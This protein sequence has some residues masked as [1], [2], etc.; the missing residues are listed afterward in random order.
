M[1]TQFV[2]ER[3]EILSVL[4]HGGQGKVARALDHQHDRV[5]ALK[6]LEVGSEFE[7]RGLLREARMLLS[8]QPHPGLPIVREDFFDGDRYCIVMDWVEGV[9]LSRVLADRGAPGLPPPE[10]AEYLSQTAAALDHLHGHQPPV[11]H[12]DVKPGN[13][14][15]VPDGDVVLVDF[16]LSVPGGTDRPGRYGGTRGYAAPELAAGTATAAA[17]VYGLAATAF[18][19]LTGG[20]PR[21]DLPTWENIPRGTAG[22]I[23]P[24]IRQGLSIDPDRRQRSPGALAAAL[25]DAI[26]AAPA[27]RIA[28]ETQV[29]T[30]LIADVR[31]YTSFTRERGDEAAA[32]LA[33]AF[34]EVAREGVESRD[35]EVIELRGDEALA[36]FGSARQ[37]L[38]AAV[39]LQVV[40]Q[41]ESSLDPS[42]P[43]AVGIGLDAGEA[44]P[45]EGGFRGA[46]LN[47]AAR[48]CASA[49]P[50][51]VLVSQGVVHLASTVEGIRLEERVPL[52]LKGLDAPVP[53]WQASHDDA[54]SGPIGTSVEQ[55]H[56]RTEKPQV[57]LDV[58][59]ELDP[60]AR[61]VGRDRDARW[62]RWAWRQARRGPG[63]IVV[64]T[65]SEGAGKTLLAA[66]AAQLAAREGASVAYASSRRSSADVEMAIAAA[67]GSSGPTLLVLDDLEAAGDAE[68]AP[69]AELVDRLDERRLLVV[70]ILRDG[71]A[72]RTRAALE[73]LAGGGERIRGLGPFDRDGVRA[74][75]ALYVEE[76]SSEVPLD[77]ILQ[78]TGGAPPDVHRM[79][80]S[81]AEGEAAR[82]LGGAA[83]LA[84]RERAG[85]RT[86]EADVVSTVIDLQRV[87][88]RGEL[89]TGPEE[90]PVADEPP[91]KGLASFDVS[92]ARY[93]FGRERL[94]AE[95]VARLA[96]SSFLAVV[97]PSGSGKSSAV[98]AGLVPTLA[99]GALPGSE[100]WIRVMLRPG[101]HPERELDRVVFAALPERLRN[102]LGS[103]QTSLEAARSLVDE[104]DGH[105]LVVVDQ[106]EELFT[107]CQDDA[108]RERFLDSLTSAVRARGVTVL[109]AIRADFY[110]RCSAHPALAELVADNHVL[111]GPMTEE[112]YRRAIELP[113]RLAGLRIDRP[114]VDALVGEVVDEPGG[115]PLLST[116][117]LELWQR[118]HGRAL[119]LKSYSETGGVRG[120][121]ARLA[122]QAYA[123]LTVDQ[124]AVAKGVLLRLSTGEGEIVTRRRVPI[125]EFDPGTNADVGAV[126]D[127]LIEAR[128]LI[129]DDGSVEV[130]HEALLREWPRLEAWLDEDRAGRRLREHLTEQAKEWERSG[131]EAGDLYRGP[132]LA[133]AREWT[134]DHAKELNDLEREFLSESRVASERETER[135]RRTNRRLRG[136]LVG[137]AVFLVVA[138]LAGGLALVQQGRARDEADRAENHARIASGRELA[139][140]AVANLDVDPER[141]ILLALAAVDATWKADRTVQSAAEEALHRA[142]QESR[143][144]RTVPQGHA[145]AVNADGSRFATTGVDGTA[146]VWETATGKRL[147]TLRGHEGKVNGV[148]FSPDG[149]LL[150]TAGSDRTARLWDGASGRPVHVLRGH[151]DPVLGVAFGPDGSLLATSSQDGTVRIWDVAAGT[152]HLV[153]RGPP[154]EEFY[155]FSGLTPAF[156]P[157]GSRVA[158]GGWFSTPVW[159][160]ATGRISMVLPRQKWE[161]VGVTFSPDGTRVA[162]AVSL[163][164]K[165]WDAQTGEP[166][167]TLSGHTGDVLGLAYS[168]D[169]Q[170]IA[171]GSDDGTA[172]V[173][174]AA[175]G[176]SLLTMAGHTRDV[177]QVA[178]T[179]DGGRL[180]TG[181][182]DG[183]ARLWDVSPTGGRDW[184]TVPG[185]ADRQ[186][187]VSFSPDGTSFAVP[188]QVT[189]VTIRDVETGAKIITLKGHDATIRRMAFSPDGTRLAGSDGSG[190]GNTWVKT[191]PVWDVTT[192][193]LVMTLRGHTGPVSAVAYSP[194][195][196]RLAT[197]SWDGTVRLWDAFSGKELHALDVGDPVFALAFSPDGRWLVA[198]DDGDESLTV[199]DADTLDRRGELRGHTDV[200][201]D[202]AFG[203]DGTVVT[204]SIDNTAKIWDLESRRELATLRGHSGPL[205]GVAVSPDGTL[206]ATGSLD[207][208]AKLWDLATGRERLTLFGHDLV[209]NTVAFSP[210]GRFLATVSG[211]GTVALHLLPIDELRDFAR[212][213]V[214]RTLTD[215]ECR[216]Y[217]H[218]ANC[219]IG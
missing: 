203:P 6:I 57:L 56:S 160:L 212:E 82:R 126:L 175:T 163:D 45:V 219:L 151:R 8:L 186:G 159:D 13:L 96:G 68:L 144:A 46:A 24:V 102:S 148:A 67:A 53:V 2:R 206:V 72:P 194:D 182:A 132:R 70:G 84:A 119:R 66:E 17:D 176:Q 209:V 192:G 11:V 165:T 29:R 90:R 14:I 1:G 87:R 131:K 196:L 63:R 218:V 166:L 177:N 141:S 174:D 162:T 155:N 164:V 64:V 191:V 158:S 83:D 153:L 134:A 138:L 136:L 103:S 105:L 198:G 168:P 122:E 135:Q 98:R 213:R 58:P 50:G 180:L 179:P 85:L 118:R 76:P 205:L 142:L 170:R 52:D 210:D 44:V 62:I 20:P 30:F 121:V 47:L 61:L 123:E 69:I 39:E 154:G 199:W 89:L 32:R 27:A 172:Q 178:F 23:E 217:L 78:A 110:G 77:A 112:E 48:L 116:A 114:L 145:I 74:V 183:T 4:G 149:S 71:T 5:V 86:A 73:R 22:R 140:S 207:G 184:L 28:A 16:G 117:L 108:E 81:W 139:A 15:L 215:E 9:S 88:E 120:A 197:G 190:Q 133:S 115:L 214:T 7:R 12:Q 204:A 31:G 189:G 19:L 161:A 75:A 200:I 18:A 125:P 99:A 111:V 37:A 92:D 124:Q 35:G 36:V 157:D 216:Q 93:F 91:F 137:T 95:M 54:F 55:R 187:G 49:G 193:E 152:Q 201:Q 10:V 65:G 185:P 127:T 80:I 129:A 113:A 51:E 128:L 94:V 146:T 188:G 150:A 169:G 60:L 34:A 195:G 43:L 167:T 156:S 41:D 33:A 109:L 3:Y 143:V 101:E 42:L 211:D 106:A 59:P 100:S 104:E 130:A 173:W 181:A 171:T 107:V 25:G 208:T 79:A 97:G 26:G 147:L 38:R 202:V 21:G 40:F